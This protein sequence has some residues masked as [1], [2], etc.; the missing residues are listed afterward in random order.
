MVDIRLN[1]RVAF[2]EAVYI[3]ETM[4]MITITIETFF[5]QSGALWGNCHIIIVYYT[6]FI[7]GIMFDLNL[8][9]K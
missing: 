6:F 5:I 3:Q 4:A 1:M 8:T 9:H 2:R 7:N